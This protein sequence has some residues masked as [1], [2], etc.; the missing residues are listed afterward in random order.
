MPREFCEGQV[1]LLACWLLLLLL[2]RV[3]I[4]LTTS[5]FY[6]FRL[7]WKHGANE[8]YPRC[9]SPDCDKY[10]FRQSGFCFKH[11]GNKLQPR[12]GASPGCKKYAVGSTQAC[13][14]HSSLLAA[15]GQGG[16]T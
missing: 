14:A 15:A 12:C 5:L 11:G 3:L 1:S 13:T 6:R 7:C 2:L 4:S 10:N 8:R 9:S 16:K